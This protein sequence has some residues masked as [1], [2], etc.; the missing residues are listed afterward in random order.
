M[1]QP[2][3]I[4]I[5]I[6]RPA[7]ARLGAVG[8]M[9]LLSAPIAMAEAEPTP[10]PVKDWAFT[11]APFIWLPAMTGDAAVDGRKVDI[12]TS[13]GDLFTE[14]DFVFAVQVELAA[15]YK[16]RFGLLFNGQWTT[17]QQDNNQLQPSDGPPFLP[18][19]G[20][21]G[22]FPIEFDL[23]NNL[24][25]FEFV[26][27]YRVGTWNLGSGPSS[28]AF[29]LEPLV[30]VRVPSLKSTLKPK[31]NLSNVEEQKTWADPILGTRMSLAF[32]GDRRG[33]LA[34]P[35]DSG[36]DPAGYRIGAHVLQVHRLRHPGFPGDRRSH[37][38]SDQRAVRNPREAALRGVEG[39]SP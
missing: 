19:G 33:H 2:R 7:A 36:E 21:P 32:G 17:L 6:S 15:W 37:L 5:P 18:P 3:W 27:A 14:S 10:E 13:V 22:I 38:R 30:G 25:L 9:L 4:G 23:D 39:R 11:V 28:P 8:L 26:G 34:E 24:G 16:E 29:T 35:A 12:D 20:G 31:G 1:N